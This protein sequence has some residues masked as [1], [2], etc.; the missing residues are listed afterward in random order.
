MCGQPA[1]LVVPS[2]PAALKLDVQSIEQMGRRPVVLG[3]SRAAVEKS[4]IVSRQML[5]LRTSGDAQ[6]LT[7]PPAGNWPVTYSVW[8]AA[9]GG[10]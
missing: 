1:A 10:S 3:S 6:V 7:G 5:S 4:G 8:L 2:S 9:P